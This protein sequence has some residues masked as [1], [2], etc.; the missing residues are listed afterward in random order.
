MFI[1]CRSGPA[2]APALVRLIDEGSTLP[3]QSRGVQQLPREQSL[4]YAPRDL[5]LF[6]RVKTQFVSKRN[7]RLLQSTK[8][9]LSI[10]HEVLKGSPH[11]RVRGQSVSYTLLTL[12]TNYPV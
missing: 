2:L 5:P 7:L 10:A 3:F 4:Q 9:A 8:F 12:P 11:V 6:N 1:F